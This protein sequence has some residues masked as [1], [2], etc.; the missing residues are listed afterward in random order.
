MEKF[1][2]NLV[3]L[4]SRA[5]CGDREN[6]WVRD[7]FTAHM[8]DEKIAEELL[9]E[10]KSPQDAYDKKHTNMQSGGRKV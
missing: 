1:L 9:A 5:D 2:A 3:E 7:T 8:S 10:T 4:A 6:E